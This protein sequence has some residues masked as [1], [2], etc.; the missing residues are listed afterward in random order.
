MDMAAHFEGM[1]AITYNPPA[2]VVID[3]L[4]SAGWRGEIL[5]QTTAQHWSRDAP[6]SAYARTE[7]PTR[8]PMQKS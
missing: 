8:S 5:D 2:R 1:V 7:E 3:D 6:S 4:D